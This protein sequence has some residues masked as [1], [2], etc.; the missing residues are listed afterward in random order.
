VRRTHA[1][2]CILQVEQEKEREK[3]RERERKGEKGRERGTE[4][5]GKINRFGPF[6]FFSPT[7]KLFHQDYPS[8]AL[9]HRRLVYVMCM[10]VGTHAQRGGNR[11]VR[12]T[13]EKKR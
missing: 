4:G 10:A 3:G 11:A 1:S 7:D 5:D 8:G 12:H 9:Q 2:G 13:I 6:P